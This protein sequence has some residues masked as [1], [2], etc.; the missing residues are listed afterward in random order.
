MLAI[1]FALVALVGWGVGDIYGTLAA[2]KIGSLLTSAW[3]MAVGVVIAVLI[4]PFV[5]QDI[6]GVNAEIL[7]INIAIGAVFLFGL[8]CFNQGLTTGNASLVGTI[9][10]SFTAVSALLSVLFFGERLTGNQLLSIVLIFLGLILSSLESVNYIFKAKFKA[11]FYAILAMFSWGIYY[12]FIRIPIE[13]IGWFLPQVITLS[14]FPVILIIMKY[15]K[16]KIIIPNFGSKEWMFIFLNGL[17][18]S[19]GEYAFNFAISKGYTSVVAPIAGAYPILFVF[20]AHYFFKDKLTFRQRI[21][22]VISLVGIMVLSIVS[23]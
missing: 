17:L 20:L 5:F 4:W 7:L 23:I 16:Q 10:A 1:F 21:G 19:G 12:A 15:Q 18:V 9:V 3:S 14:L 22:I 11:V 2:R 6:S 13:Q 8:V